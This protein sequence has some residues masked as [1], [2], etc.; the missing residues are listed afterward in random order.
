MQPSVGYDTNGV[1][2]VPFDRVRLFD[3]R[4]QSQGTDVV[5]GF[6]PHPS[7]DPDCIGIIIS[8]QHGGSIHPKY[9]V[10]A[11]KIT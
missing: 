4:G 7:Y 9:A 10:K 1:K 11:A 8:R 6:E 2:L 3:D 5:F